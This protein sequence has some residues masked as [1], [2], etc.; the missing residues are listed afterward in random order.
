MSKHLQN[1]A[2]AC[3]AAELDA[4]NRSELTSGEA[5][6]AMLSACAPFMDDE[7]VNTLQDTAETLAKLL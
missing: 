2:D 6:D 1:L 3:S 5:L 7:T 4:S